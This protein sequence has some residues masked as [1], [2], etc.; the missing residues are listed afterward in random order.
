[1]LGLA[2]SSRR[3]QPC[4]V[5]SSS[6]RRVEREPADEQQVEADALTASFAASRTWSAPDGAVSGPM[7]TATAS[8]RPPP[9]YVPAA[10]IHAPAYG[11][12]DSNSG[13]RP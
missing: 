2:G 6:G 8:P 13:A 10:W 1:M 4:V 12:S 5:P 11:S 9:V 3:P 7:A